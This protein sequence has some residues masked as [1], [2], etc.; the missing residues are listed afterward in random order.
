M[1]PF[2]ESLRHAYPFGP[3][4]VVVDVGAFTGGF[5]KTMHEKY[6]CIVLAFE[7]VKAHFEQASIACREYPRINLFNCGLGSHFR[8]E[9]FGVQSDSSGVFAGSEVKE[10]VIILPIVDHLRQVYAAGKFDLLKLNCEGMEYEILESL[11]DHK[12]LTMFANIAAQFH[13]CAPDYQKRY[14]SIAAALSQTHE[15]QWREPFVWE[16]WTIRK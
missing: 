13:T 12:A 3:Q 9:M 7:P 8:T 15:L 10:K 2:T 5:A 4:S 6:K 14:D 16:G 1:I 11:I